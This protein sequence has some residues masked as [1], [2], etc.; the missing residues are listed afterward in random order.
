MTVKI[1]RQTPVINNLPPGK[2]P[3]EAINGQSPVILKGVVKHWPLVMLGK[4]SS[5]KVVDYLTPYYNGKPSFAYVGGSDIKGRFFY[6]EDATQLNYQSEQ[7]QVD[8]FLERLIEVEDQPNPPSLYIA[9]NVIDTHFP[10]LREHNDLTIPRPQSDIPL[11]SNRVSIWIGNKTTAC[12]HYDA[13]DNLACCIMGKRRFT[14]FP[15]SQVENLYPGPLHLTPGGQA[16]SMVDFDNPDFDKYPNFKIA[17]DHAEIAKLE[18]GDVLYLPSMWW[19]Q[20]EGLANFNVLV[21]YWWSES[22]LY[23]GAAMNVL[24]HAMLSMRHKPEHEKRAWKHLFDYYIFDNTGKA[25]AHLPEQAQGYLG[26]LD[27]QKARSLRAMLLNKL[28]R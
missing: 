26:E 12:A 13:S 15:P 17:L 5:R 7:V 3:K 22:P 1:S 23:C 24:Y 4:Q 14:L 18:P 2:I 28:N 16:L 10:G 25:A 8:A 20:V 6:N 19:H 11:E 21:N 9:S 27:P